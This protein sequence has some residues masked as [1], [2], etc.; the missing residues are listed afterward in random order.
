MKLAKAQDDLEKLPAET[1]SE[2]WF[3]LKRGRWF[4]KH[5]KS[6]RSDE[7]QLID[8]IHQYIEDVKKVI[9]Q[10]EYAKKLKEERQEKAEAATASGESKR[11]TTEDGE[12]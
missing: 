1:F 6:W 11:T 7:Q 9:G 2:K 4:F 8:D 3:W 12:N 10:S 5:P